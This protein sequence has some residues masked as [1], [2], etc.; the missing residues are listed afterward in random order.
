MT[1]DEDFKLDTLFLKTSKSTGVLR[2]PLCELAIKGKINKDRLEDGLLVISVPAEDN[3]NELEEV[4]FSHAKFRTFLNQWLTKNV[5]EFIKAYGTVDDFV[6]Q[7][8]G[9]NI[10]TVVSEF[11]KKYE[12]S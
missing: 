1:Q 2:M 9:D 6:I 10:L 4:S 12:V 11:L 8:E 3:S 5:S 7:P